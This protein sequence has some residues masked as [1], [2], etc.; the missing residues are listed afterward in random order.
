MSHTDWIWILITISFSSTAGVYVAIRK[1]K[2]YTTTPVNILHRRGDIELQEVID[3]IQ[4]NYIRDID[5]SS[6]PQYPQAMVNNN[7]IW[8]NWDN[9]PR[10]SQIT[11]HFINSPLELDSLDFIYIF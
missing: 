6:L 10:Y 3:P 4:S 5:L 8:I 11:N 9:P 2:Q 7:H 1:I